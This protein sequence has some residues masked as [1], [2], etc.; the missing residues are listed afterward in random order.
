MD[1]GDGSIA[2]SVAPADLL[3]T[4]RAVQQCADGIGGLRVEEPGLDEVYQ[5]LLEA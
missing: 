1:I 5:R 3:P 4:M 2:L